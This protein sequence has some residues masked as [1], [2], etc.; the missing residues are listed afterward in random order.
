[1]ITRL[2]TLSS[3][4]CA[5]SAIQAPSGMLRLALHMY[6]DSAPKCKYNTADSVCAL[7]GLL[8]GS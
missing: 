2:G 6:Q 7:L 1:M 5:V 8:K 4:G 3:P